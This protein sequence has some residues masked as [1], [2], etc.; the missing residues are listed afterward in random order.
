M[1]PRH[2]NFFLLNKNHQAAMVPGTGMSLLFPYHAEIISDLGGLRGEE[3]VL[4]RK[5]KQQEFNTD[6]K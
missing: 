4:R 2:A 3:K 5:L 6:P 1:V